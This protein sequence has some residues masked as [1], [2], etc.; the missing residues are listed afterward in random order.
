MYI[1]IL[2]IKILWLL[3]IPNLFTTFMDV[4]CFLYLLSELH[5]QEIVNTSEQRAYLHIVCGFNLKV[6]KHKKYLTS[7]NYRCF[8]NPKATFIHFLPENPILIPV[9]DSMFSCQV[10]LKTFN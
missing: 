5:S 4:F 1:L 9:L 10:S 8:L 7:Y 6:L 3:E 2:C